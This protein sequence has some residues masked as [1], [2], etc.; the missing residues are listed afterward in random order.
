MAK[1]VYPVVLTPEEGGYYAKFPDIES[2]YTQGDNLAD[3]LEM[4]KDILSIRLCDYE[5]EKKDIPKA[6][7][8][9]ALT[10]ENG[11][12]LSLVSADTMEYRRLWDSKAMKKTLTIPTWLNTLAEKADVNFSAVL[13]KALKEELQLIE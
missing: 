9:E 2:C 5:D 13:Q 12:I 3:T 4:A 7:A 6:S 11:Q 10:L 1:Y 8:Q